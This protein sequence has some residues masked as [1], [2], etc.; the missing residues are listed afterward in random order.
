MVALITTKKEKKKFIYLKCD[1]ALKIIFWCKD[2]YVSHAT[3]T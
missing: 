2:G 3:P 1:L